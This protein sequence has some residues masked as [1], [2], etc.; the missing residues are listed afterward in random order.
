MEKRYCGQCGARLYLVKTRMI[1]YHYFTGKPSFVLT[2][3]C[4]NW[5]WWNIR[6]LTQEINKDY[7]E[8][9]K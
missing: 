6:H 9:E 3:R 2:L 7:E 5:R 4:P 1:G 8:K